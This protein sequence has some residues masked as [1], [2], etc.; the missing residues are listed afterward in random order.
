MWTD[1]RLAWNS[2]DYD[3]LTGLTFSPRDLWLP[4]LS[5]YNAAAAKDIPIEV[6]NRL[7]V[8]PDGGVLLIMPFDM[9]FSCDANLRYWPDDTH[10]CLLKIGSWTHSGY[11][12]DLRVKEG[13]APQ[14]NND[15]SDPTDWRLDDSSITR[16]TMHYACCEEPYYDARVMLRVS[17]Q[18]PLYTWLIK[19]PAACLI[20]LT[21]VVFV[22]PPGAGEKIT[23]GGICVLLNLVFLVFTND[24]VRSAPTHT[25]L[26]A[27]PAVST[28]K[29]SGAVRGMTAASWWSPRGWCGRP[30]GPYLSPP[31]RAPSSLRSRLRLGPLGYVRSQW[32]SGANT[33]LA[34]GCGRG[35]ACN[36]TSSPEYPLGTIKKGTSSMC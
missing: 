17:R 22:M 33:P 11:I 10:D 16:E 3:G 19:V 34:S 26:L 8:T 29:C 20:L 12:I 13:L 7:V 28:P 1:N 18:A 32:Q 30:R 14:I 21:M 36:L 25:P 9:P 23:F 35:A 2:N 6:M 27:G 15:T 4:D 5:F 24:T 31:H